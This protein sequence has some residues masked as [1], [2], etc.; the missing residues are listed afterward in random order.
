MNHDNLHDK[1]VHPRSSHSRTL[2]SL[3]VL[4]AV[5]ML[6]GCVINAPEIEAAIK[7]CEP[8]GGLSF[9]EPKSF[10]YKAFCKDG[11]RVEG[12]VQP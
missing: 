9:V 2:S 11:T 7:A 5:A 12:R 4:A 3:S 10:G 8:H 1:L 6:A